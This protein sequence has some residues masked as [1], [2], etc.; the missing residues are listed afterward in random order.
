METGNFNGNV[1]REGE[2]HAEIG[3]LWIPL[4][5]A[6]NRSN[7][8]VEDGILYLKPTLTADFMG[9]GAMTDGGVLS[10]WSSEPSSQ[11]TGT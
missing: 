3:N 1:V 7:S 10:L 11:C 9:E 8:F 6:N 2:I 4:R 5:Y